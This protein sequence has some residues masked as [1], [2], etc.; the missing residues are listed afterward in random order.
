ML[1]EA[2]PH[3]LQTWIEPLLDYS[4]RSRLNFVLD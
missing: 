2:S 4:F 3:R 1:S